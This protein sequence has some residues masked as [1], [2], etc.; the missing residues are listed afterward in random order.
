MPRSLADRY[1]ATKL[2]E[3]LGPGGGRPELVQG[4]LSVPREQAVAKLLELT[5]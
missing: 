4:K 1:D 5:R 3:F 2:K